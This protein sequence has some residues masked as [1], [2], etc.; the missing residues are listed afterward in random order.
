[1]ND[2]LFH[3]KQF[4]VA[5]SRSSMK[6]GVDAVLIGSWADCQGMSILDVGTG[7]GVIALM[8]AQRND[9]ADVL[10]IDVDAASIEEASDNFRSSGWTDRLEA[11][12]IAFADVKHL[13]RHFDRIISNPPYFDSGVTDF[14]TPRNVARHQGDLS[15]SVLIADSPSL[16]TAMG[17]LALIVPAQ[18]FNALINTAERSHLRLS[19]ACFIKGTQKK[20]AKRVMME[21]VRDIFPGE[22][23]IETLTMYD[24]KGNLTEEYVALGKDFYYNY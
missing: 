2:G 14:S 4:S 17:K 20:E 6:V 1:M 24:G 23:C 18:F 10:A 5:H 22:P 8:M 7:C 13:G 3:F 15:P 16:L 11:S 9:S 21:F 12:L 19:R